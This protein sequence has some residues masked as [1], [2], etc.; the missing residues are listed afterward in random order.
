M[1]NTRK[2]MN[3]PQILKRRLQEDVES[4]VFKHLSDALLTILRTIAPR[5]LENISHSPPSAR[6][7]YKPQAKERV[8]L[9]VPD[10][11]YSVLEN[12]LIGMDDTMPYR[13]FTDLVVSFVAEYYDISVLLVKS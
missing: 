6:K 11:L 1:G 10:R 4:S 3:F 9:I 13:S 2:M 8:V 5:G 7:F 12:N